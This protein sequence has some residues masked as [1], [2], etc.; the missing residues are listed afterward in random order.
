M[1]K[2]HSLL[3]FHFCWKAILPILCFVMLLLVPEVHAVTY[4]KAD[5]PEGGDGSS[6]ETA[7]RNVE[8]AVSAASATEDKTVY[9]A[10]GIYVVTNKMNVADGF[11]IYGGFPGVLMDETPDDRDAEAYK[12]VLTGDKELDDYWAHGEPAFGEY[13]IKFTDL[14]DKPL[15]A[16]GI[17]HLPPPYT[18]EYDVYALR[19]MGD[20]TKLAFEITEGVRSSYDGLWFMGFAPYGSNGNCITILPGAGETLISNC[21]FMGN[22]GNH[23]MVMDR[24]GTAKITFC[25]FRFN[26]TQQRASAIC[27][28]GATQ[29]EDCHFES[30]SRNCCNGAGVIY[31]WAGSGAA[32]RRCVFT[33]CIEKATLAWEEGGYGGS[34]VIASSEGGSFVEFHDSVISNCFSTSPFPRGAPILSLRNGFVSGTTFCNNYMEVKPCAS[35]SYA[36]FGTTSASDFTLTYEGC[37]FIGNTIT[38][39]QLSSDEGMYGLSVVGMP[40]DGCRLSVVNCTFGSNNIEGAENDGLK[41]L[42]SRGLFCPVSD[43]S[44]NTD[45]GVA[46]CTFAG[47]AEQGLFDIVQIGSQH[48]YPLTV[49]NSLFMGEGE[50]TLSPFYVVNPDLF[51]VNDCTIKNKFS[52]DESIDCTGLQADE[53]PFLPDGRIDTS[54][55]PCLIPAAHT[56][57]LRETADIASDGT[58]PVLASRF[59]YRLR[60]DTEWRPLVALLG[61]NV[62]AEPSPVDDAN[63]NA[64][65]FGSFT[66]GA[67]QPLTDAAEKGVTLTIRRKPLSGGTLSRPSTQAVASGNPIVPVTA[68]PSGTS[69]FLGWYEED[70]TRFSESRELAIDS[71]ET[72]RILTATF[73]TP[74]RSVTFDLD[75]AGTFDSNGQSTIVV[76]VHQGDAFPSVPAFTMSQEWFVDGWSPAFPAFVPASNTTFRADYITRNVRVVHVVPEGEVPVESNRSGDSWENATDDLAAAYREAGRYRGEVWMKGGLYTIKTTLE[77]LSNVSIIGGFAGT[78]SSSSVADPTAHP[79][80]LSG[81]VKG[82]TFWKPNG[83]DVSGTARTNLW[84]DGV[85]SEPNPSGLDDYWQPSGNVSDD[86]SYFF[87]S[88]LRAMENV[89]FEGLTF[90]S[91]RLG[92]ISLGTPSV[93]TMRNCRFL[94]N[95][96]G[97][98][99][100]GFA[101]LYATKGHFEIENC[102]FIGNYHAMAFQ[103]PVGEAPNVVR[104]CRFRE[105]FSWGM[106]SCLRA[107]GDARLVVEDCDFIRNCGKNEHWGNAA[108]FSCST[109]SPTLVRRCLFQANR[110]RGHCRGAFQKENTGRL[111]VEACRFLD[112]DAIISENKGSH[113]ACMAISTGQ[114]LVRDCYFA[115][116]KIA[117]GGNL[118]GNCHGAILSAIS[119]ESQFF[120][121]SMVGN[122]AE[123]TS[124][125]DPGVGIL[126]GS[127]DM[128]FA[129]CLIDGSRLVGNS[130]ECIPSSSDRNTTFAMINTI[131]RNEAENYVPFRFY[132]PNMTLSLANTAISKLDVASLATGNNGYLYDVSDNPGPVSI[133]RSGPAGLPARGIAAFSPYVRAGRPVWLTAKG[134]LYFYDERAN[135]AKPW[136]RISQKNN[137]S[138]TVA[139]LTLES[140]LVPDAFG[141]PR[142]IGRVAYG[143]LNAPTSGTFLLL[144]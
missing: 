77:G 71:L 36:L 58:A 69:S 81:D 44:K 99:Y 21:R 33:R 107:E 137:Y 131:V 115:G 8:E 118:G 102:E 15:F 16:G 96:T 64:R 20:N 144:R 111:T 82:D 126:A 121:C 79:T 31:F 114:L 106:G 136:R 35:S 78:E 50:E 138:D 127:R 30:L 97:S 72:N 54:H 40:K 80:I 19:F 68:T 37:S 75:V 59:H 28:R 53:I 9:A 2:L 108:V 93:V 12:T 61:G 76:P 122:I 47:P 125:G 128:A 43:Y 132:S 24:A 41:V 65:V 84:V 92:V 143:P 63:G 7:Y 60:G 18:G 23:G 74:I 22:F 52:L 70:G 13:T 112:N 42:R 110:V 32:V 140:P 135:P 124:T 1:K 109:R 134:N 73:G 39:P 34:G 95:G 67:V 94:A 117:I 105:N 10:G 11:K 90:T 4:L 48:K 27:T 100:L 3:P 62:A 14:E 142:T 116:N 123:N 130:Y 129:N 45:L 38:T 87:C 113:S 141:A 119:G 83:I 98:Q 86:Q 51:M 103:S 120:N 5:A 46:N 104:E 139:D 55:V 89:S 26:Q 57:G 56:P 25:D 91:F 88:S 85:F 29:I 66:R 49:V 6:W 133:T 101:V 17:V